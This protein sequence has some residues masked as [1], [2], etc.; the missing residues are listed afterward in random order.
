MPGVQRLSRRVFLRQFGTTSFAIAVFGLS[1]CSA[2]EPGVK[3]SA[4]PATGSMTAEGLSTTTTSPPT[5]STVSGAPLTYRRVKLGSVSAYILVRSGS[6]A[7]VD[8]GV[9]GSAS[10]IE[11]GLRGAGL[12]W[13]DV[14]HVVLTHR[15]PDHIGSA[16]AVLMAATEATAYAGEADLPHIPAP[17]PIIP[18]A[19]GDEVFGLQVIHTPGHTPGH[20]CVLDPTEGILVAGDALNGADGGVIGP[21]PSF[22]PDMDLANQ[23]VKKL[24]GFSF[25][26]VLFGHGE[27]VEIGAGSLVAALAAD[28]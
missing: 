14:E 20:I 24:A 10:D 9:S 4:T 13:N 6:A 11:A 5:V 23:S 1:A 19:D 21:N 26:T 28:L 22:T 7:I 16:E 18:V 25:E 12:S 27:P 2:S 17:R 8:T 15:H 3:S